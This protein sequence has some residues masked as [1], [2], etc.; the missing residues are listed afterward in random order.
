[1]VKTPKKI[2]MTELDEI[3]SGKTA[4]ELEQE[5]AFQL[6]MGETPGGTI[7]SELQYRLSLIKNKIIS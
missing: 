3:T 1:M 5:I 7:I 2:N 6:H 4:E